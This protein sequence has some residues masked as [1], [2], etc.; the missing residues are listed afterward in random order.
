MS[1]RPQQVPIH[2]SA[3]IRKLIWIAQRRSSYLYNSS[4]SV[5]EVVL[6]NNFTSSVTPCVNLQFRI[7]AQKCSL[8]CTNSAN[9]RF[10]EQHVMA[11][12]TNLSIAPT[13]DELRN[14]V[15][16]Q[17]KAVNRNRVVLGLKIIFAAFL[18]CRIS[19]FRKFQVVSFKRYFIV[20][21][22]FCQS[23][24]SSRS[25]RTSHIRPQFHWQERTQTCYPS[26]DIGRLL[27]AKTQTSMVCV[28]SSKT[29]TCRIEM[30][31]TSV[32]VISAIISSSRNTRMSKSSDP[33]INWNQTRKQSINWWTQVLHLAKSAID[34]YSVSV[35]IAGRVLTTDCIL[36]VVTFLITAMWRPGSGMITAEKGGHPSLDD[37]SV[38]TNGLPPPTHRGLTFSLSQYHL[39]TSIFCLYSR[40][41]SWWTLFTVDNCQP[42]TVD[43]APCIFGQKLCLP[44][45]TLSTVDYGHYF[46]VFRTTFSPNHGQSTKN[47]KK[48]N[49]T[50]IFTTFIILV[51][52]IFLLYLFTTYNFLKESVIE[53]YQ[54]NTAFSGFP[55]LWTHQSHFQHLWRWQKHSN[56]ACRL[57][58]LGQC[59]P[60]WVISGGRLDI[61]THKKEL[62]PTDIFQ[63]VLLLSVLFFWDL[64]LFSDQKHNTDLWTRNLCQYLTHRMC[65]SDACGWFIWVIVWVTKLSIP[66]TSI[67]TITQQE[68]YAK[69][70]HSSTTP[71]W[72][73]AQILSCSETGGG[74]SQHCSFQLSID[75]W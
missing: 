46:L 30:S 58:N 59:Q 69:K 45:T 42:W 6:E 31:L 8:F 62:A 18:S 36:V 52:P 71:T 75:C 29:L 9:D 22:I 19:C 61:L 10:L 23:P 11:T 49:F 13:S 15:R 5:T 43:D 7:E 24:W 48:G 21:S 16:I 38:I 66:K 41:C 37:N 3:S 67:Q 60:C 28:Q 26:L 56:Q 1:H 63:N 55:F 39:P 72:R 33:T 57:W 70:A 32:S 50:F 47:L 35:D 4:H 2:V 53:L 14:S 20:L 74:A 54:K 40:L 64:K 25:V 44:W 73:N 17:I 68:G 12:D 51:R 34:S 27:P 65:T